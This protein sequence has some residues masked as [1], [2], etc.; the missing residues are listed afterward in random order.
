MITSLRYASLRPYIDTW[1]QKKNGTWTHIRSWLPPTARDLLQSKRFPGPRET[2]PTQ[3]A[4]VLKSPSDMS[5][6]GRKGHLAQVE[7]VDRASNA[8]VQAYA[9]SLCAHWLWIHNHKL[10]SE[11]LNLF[12]SKVP[13][14]KD[15]HS[16]VNVFSITGSLTNRTWKQEDHLWGVKDLV[17]CPNLGVVEALETPLD[18]NG[19]EFWAG[20]QCGR[21]HILFFLSRLSWVL[22]CPVNVCISIWSLADIPQTLASISLLF[23]N[24]NLWSRPSCSRFSG[25]VGFDHLWPEI[26]SNHTLEEI[27]T[28]P[29]LVVFSDLLP[30]VAHLLVFLHLDHSW[31]VSHHLLSWVFFLQIKGT[32]RESKV[33]KSYLSFHLKT[34]NLNSLIWVNW[35]KRSWV[36]FSRELITHQV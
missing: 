10:P 24:H 6:S 30:S 13:T 34:I 8:K 27:P 23:S 18:V 32:E 1:R 14:S 17:P 26:C 22:P 36:E 16:W 31:P 9:L 21:L 28:A 25:K 3:A 7:R 29:F 4:P 2:L 15:F 20:W 11:C 5:C 35:W 33:A 12:W 19:Q